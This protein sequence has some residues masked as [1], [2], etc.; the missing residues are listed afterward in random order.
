[1]F[2]YVMFVKMVEESMKYVSQ[3]HWIST[4]CAGFG[5]IFEFQIRSALMG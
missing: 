1:M 3:I 2:A 5:R 4:V